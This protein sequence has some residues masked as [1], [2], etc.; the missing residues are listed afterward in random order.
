[1]TTEGER[2]DATVDPIDIL[3][4]EPNPG[5]TRL[6]TEKFADAKLTNAVHTVVDGET[7]LDFLHQRDEYADRSC[8]DLI[9]LEPKLPG[10]DGVEL[11]SKLEGEPAL[12]EITVIVLTSSEAGEEIVKSHGLEA[13]HYLRK[14]V[15][16]DE[17]LEF[18]QQVEEFWLAIVEQPAGD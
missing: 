1:M 2:S 3:L 14:P 9:V 12:N 18:V 13:D 15:E 10:I 16:P 6:F 4:I 8:P 11:L 17:F 7:A 5:D